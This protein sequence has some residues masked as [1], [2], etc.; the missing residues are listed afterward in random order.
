MEPSPELS[1]SCSMSAVMEPTPNDIVCLTIKS[2]RHTRQ[3][4]ARLMHFLSQ[5]S[6]RLSV[7][8]RLKLRS[9]SRLCARLDKQLD[10]LCNRAEHFGVYM[11]R[12]EAEAGDIATNALFAVLKEH[13]QSPDEQLCTLDNELP[14][15]LEELV[16]GTK[17]K[18][19]DTTPT[20][21]ELADQ[22][23]SGKIILR[24]TVEVN[25]VV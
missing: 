2:L 15:S 6:G 11:P 16:A 4:S 13:E 9:A 19:G 22:I 21:C 7:V 5:P 24:S 25:S 18:F 20:I 10:S 8:D 17:D 23:Y 12:S 1:S 14:Y 3:E